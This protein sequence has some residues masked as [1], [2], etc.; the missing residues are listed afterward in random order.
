MSTIFH[1]IVAGEAP[2]YK[3]LENE[4]HLAFLDIFPAVSSPGQ[5]VVVPKQFQPS[6]FTAVDAEILSKATL[7]AQDVAKLMETKLENVLRVVA[8]VEGLQIDYFHIKLYPV[9]VD[10]HLDIDTIA[11]LDDAELQRL[12]GVLTA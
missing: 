10:I 2:C 1:K 6:K 8:V 9:Y 4:E 7:F 5:I 12:Q 3:I 11:K